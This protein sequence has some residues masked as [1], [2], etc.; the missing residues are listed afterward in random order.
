MAS[1]G[2]E[3]KELLPFLKGEERKNLCNTPERK[4]DS[5][6]KQERVKRRDAAFLG[7]ARKKGEVCFIRGSSFP[8]ERLPTGGG[9]TTS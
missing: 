4:K 5:S 6:Y 1:R 7:P 9:S 3:K 2:R 8:F